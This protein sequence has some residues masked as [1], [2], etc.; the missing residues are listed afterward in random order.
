MNKR[1]GHTGVLIARTWMLW[2]FAR[3][4]H[5]LQLKSFGLDVI[6]PPPPARPAPPLPQRLQVKSLGLD[7]TTPPTPPPSNRAHAEMWHMQHLV[8]R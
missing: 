3:T 4:G 1:T 6:T 7:G 8:E 5:K 2:P